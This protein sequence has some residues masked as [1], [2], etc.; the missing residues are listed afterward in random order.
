MFLTVIIPTRNRANLLKS[1]LFSIKE[2]NLRRNEFEVLAINNGS[3]DETDELIDG[4]KK[5]T[6]NLTN[7]YASTPGLHTGRH[8]GMLAANGEVL[9][10]ADDDIEALPTWL[11]TIADAFTDPTL[12]M[13]G[14]NNL[15]LFMH[16]PPPWLN[17]LWKRQQRNG[18]RSLPW[19]SIQERPAGRYPIS[20]Y[21]VWGCNFA[22]RKEVLLAAG[23]FHPD[24]M[25]KE[26]I[27]FR[28]D[29][30]THVSRYVAEKGLKCLFDSGASIYHKI[31]H[32]RMTLGYFRQRG[33]NQGVSDS[34]T[35]LRGEGVTSDGKHS[36]ASRVARWGRK[37]LRGLKSRLS[38]IGETG[39]RKAL[40]EFDEG[41]R[42]G[43]AFHQA[44]YRDDPEI[45]EW[46]HRE[47]YY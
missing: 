18:G 3:E 9:V 44:A 20:P 26:L 43:F 24:G 46:V 15:P 29:G 27:R 42:D 13:M 5:T 31:T 17:E 34:Y 38:F 4:L 8:V 16:P 23:G 33:F 37:N 11:S 7:I 47:R 2:Q 28:G 25:P 36:L 6:P 32:E 30:E 14:G 35:Q 12:A 19:L 10:F 41:H 40:R 39:E 22:I 45:R 1:T 21:Q